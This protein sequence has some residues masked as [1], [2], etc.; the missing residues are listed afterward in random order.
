MREA[1]GI[2]FRNLNGFQAGPSLSQSVVPSKTQTSF[3]TLSQ[4]SR[5]PSNGGDTHMSSADSCP[6]SQSMDMSQKSIMESMSQ[7]IRLSVKKNRGRTIAKTR[8]L[9]LRVEFTNSVS[10]NDLPPSLKQGHLETSPTSTIG[11]NA[12][13]PLSGGHKHQTNRFVVTPLGKIK[14]HSAVDLSRYADRFSYQK[15]PSLTKVASPRGGIRVFV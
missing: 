14:W 3:L 1:V 12:G 7:S 13:E 2:V 11:V 10:P 8:Y 15:L 4:S 5:A 9:T 6:R